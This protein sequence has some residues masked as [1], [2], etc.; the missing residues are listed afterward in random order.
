LASVGAITDPAA[1]CRDGRQIGVA[2]VEVS[3]KETDRMRKAGTSI[4]WW[5]VVALVATILAVGSIAVEAAPPGSQ[6]PSAN[7]TPSQVNPNLFRPDLVAKLSITQSV[8]GG[9]GVVVMHGLV[10]NQGNRDYVVPPA[11]PVDSEYMV[12]TRHPPHTWVQEGDVKLLGHKSIGNQVKTGAANCVAHDSSLTI[13]NVVRFIVPGH[14]SPLVPGE[15]LVEKQLVFRLMKNYPTGAPPF[16]ASEDRN[17]DN[18]TAIVE[19]R[20]TEKAP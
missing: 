1:E 3:R 5:G 15:R 12:Y 2:F 8:L 6:P 14:L 11:S 18:N 10:C 19:F 20:Y 7:S 13:P 9:S 4:G 16:T 17:P